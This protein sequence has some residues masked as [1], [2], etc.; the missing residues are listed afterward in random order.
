MRKLR[1]EYANANVNG[2]IWIFDNNNIQVDVLDDSE[3]QLTTK[4][5]FMDNNKELVII[6]VYAK[7]ETTQR[8]DL[9]NDIYGICNSMSLPWLV[10]G[11]FNVIIDAEE[12]IEGLPV[13]PQE[14]KDFVF[15]K[16]SCGLLDIKFKGSPF[17]WWN[18]RA[19]AECIFKRLDRLLIIQQFF[20]FPGK[21]ELEHLA[22]TGS[23]HAPLLLTCG[24]LEKQDNRPFGFLKIWL[25]L[26]ASLR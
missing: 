23:D 9:W 13:Y 22:R 5:K 16:N 21:A 14:Y 6:S 26:K 24:G 18:G 15:C 19:E 2:K 1:M 17:T 7:C 11:D 4:L 20:D 3:Q 8:I 25:I 12:K 10:G